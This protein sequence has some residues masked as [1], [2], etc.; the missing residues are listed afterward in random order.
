MNLF[1]TQNSYYFV[2]RHFI[3]LFD[4][5]NALSKLE[6]FISSNGAK[7][8]NLNINKEKII[9]IKTSKELIFKKHLSINGQKII[10]FKPDFSV[11]WRVA[12]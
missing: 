9:L 11:F 2:H 5:E 1:I 6:N 12:G 7:H 10:I 4:N 3:Q 8:Y